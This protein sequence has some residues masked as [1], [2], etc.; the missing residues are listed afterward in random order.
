MVMRGR[1]DLDDFSGCGRFDGHVKTR[2]GRKIAFTATRIPECGNTIR[3]PGEQCDGTDGTLYGF[4]DC[5]GADCRVK[6]GCLVACDV[7]RGFPCEGADE[8]CV[9]RCGYGGQCYPRAD[10]ACHAGPVC[11]CSGEITYSSNC[12]AYDAGTGVGN[13]G[14]C[15]PPP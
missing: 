2:S 4:V 11:D 14:V 13:D 5:C 3:E 7:R 1:F 6:P 10:V 8:L 9:T 15:V 12:A